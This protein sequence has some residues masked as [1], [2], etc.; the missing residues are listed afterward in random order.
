M[1]AEMAARRALF[2]QHMQRAFAAEVIEY[3][4]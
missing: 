2:T 1:G 3:G 4:V